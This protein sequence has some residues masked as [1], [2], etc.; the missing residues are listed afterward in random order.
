MNSDAKQGKNKT[1]S[2]KAD[3]NG[4]PILHEG[5][6]VFFMSE[7]LDAPVLLKSGLSIGK[8]KDIAIKINGSLY[9]EATHIVVSRKWGRPDM[10]IP[11][12]N[13]WEV[14]EHQVVVDV[15]ENLDHFVPA[16]G[17]MEDFVLVNEKMMDKKI[18]DM[19]DREVEVVYDIQLVYADGK[20]YLTHVDASRAGLLRRIKLGFLNKWLFGKKESPDLV[21]W[22]YVHVPADLGRLKGQLR[23]NVQKEKLK[24]IH[25]ADL[26]DILEELGHKERMEIFDGLDTEKAAD[27]L[28]E[29]EPRVQRE[30]IKSIRQE[31]IGEIFKSMTSAQLADLFSILPNEEAQKFIESLDSE[32][33]RKVRAI[34]SQREENVSSLVSRTYVAFPGDITV[35]EAL[36]RYRKEALDRA[37][38]MY[39]YIIAEDDTLLGVLDVRELIQADPAALLEDIMVKNVISVE[40]D[41]AK[42]DVEALFKKYLF[43]AVP[44]V[45][46]QDHL[47][48]V[49]RFKDVFIGQRSPISNT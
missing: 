23:I 10:L 28:E 11:W 29:I 41:D 4:A 20:L 30:L 49:I 15:S 37:V 16:L 26:A 43:R 47:I 14:N 32:K 17:S 21:P 46:A 40:P 24:D 38:I 25:P 3:K 6:N 8:L 12:N 27:T 7:V 5:V 22:N 9:P 34:L 36:D 1:A 13:V 33:A 35:S 2:I 45:D 18:I 48:G 44:V 42:D 19:E 39:T 31:R